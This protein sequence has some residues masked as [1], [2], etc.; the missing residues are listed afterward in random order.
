GIQPQRLPRIE[1]CLSRSRK[2]PGALSV[3][4]TST[5]CAPSLA[6]QTDSTPTGR[7]DYLLLALLYDTGARVQELVNLCP[8]HFRLDRLPFVRILGKGRKERIVP[9][10]PTTAKLVRNYLEETSRSFGDTTPLLPNHR[11]K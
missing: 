7:R 5:N 3:I 8:S 11:G 6:V 10:M 2:R 1:C 4:S 9:L